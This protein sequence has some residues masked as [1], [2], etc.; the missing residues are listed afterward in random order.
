M[1]KKLLQAD[2][3]PPLVRAL[4]WLVLMLSLA[5]TYWVWHEDQV[6][7]QENLQEEF[8]FRVAETIQRIGTRMSSYELALRGA[9]GLFQASDEV[10]RAEFRSYVDTLRLDNT[11]PGI[12]GIGYALRIDPANRKRHVE[13]IR[14]EGFPHYD[15]TPP[16]ER[17][18]Y[19]AIVFLEPFAGANLRA[20]GYDMHS[21]AVRRAAMDSARDEGNATL[22]GKLRLVQEDGRNEQAGFLMYQPVYRKG[23]P[24][25]TPEQRRAAL[26][27][28][29]Y[30]PFRAGNLMAGITGKYL[31]ESVSALELEIYDAGTISPAALL[32]QS[33]DAQ[34]GAVRQAKFIAS[35]NLMIGRHPWT[36][37]IRS[38][39]TFEAKLHSEKTTRVAVIGVIGSLLLSLIVWQLVHGRER[40][41][42]FARLLNQ[43]LIESEA[44]FRNMADSAPI[45]IWMA[46]TDLSYFWFNQGWLEFTGRTLKEEAG[47]GWLAGIHPDNLETRR[48]TIDEALKHHRPFKSQH[49]LRHHDGEH[50]WVLESAVPRFDDSG[51][52]SGYIGSCTDVT[53]SKVN[54]QVLEQMMSEAYAANRAKSEFLATMSHEIRTPMNGV[55]GMTDLILET[56]L[57]GEQRRY[58]QV[59][60]NSAESL[61][62]IINDILDLSKI[63]SGKLEIEQIAFNIHSLLDELNELYTLRAAEKSIAFNSVATPDVPVWVRG[64]PTRI[65]QILDNFIGN[66]LKFIQRGQI[67]LRVDLLAAE[68][69][70]VTLRFAV[71]DT[72]IGIAPQQQQ[73]LFTPFSQADSSTTRKYGGTGLGLAICK[74]LT[75]LMGGEIG[76]ESKV[77]EGSTFWF[78]AVFALAKSHAAATPVEASAL[79]TASAPPALLSEAT[80]EIRL[81]LVEDN[82]VNRE[83]AT[84]QLCK[85][86]YNN[87]TVALNGVDA[88]AAVARQPFDLILMDC[89]MPLMDGYQATKKLRASGC[90]LPI[91]AMTANAMQGDRER[92]T[93][94][95]MD[96]YLAKPFTPKQLT[97]ML[98]RW[99]NQNTAAESLPDTQTPPGAPLIFDRTGALERLANDKE[100]LR[101]SLAVMLSDSLE[102]VA[103]LATAIQLGHRDEAGYHA[104]NIRDSAANVGAETLGSAAA[105]LEEM[106]RRGELASL[107]EA[108]R[109]VEK[110]LADFALAVAECL[111]K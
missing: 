7:N 17:D 71:H 58:A 46:D 43:Q 27:G 66:S 2:D 20:F 69:E 67:D 13:G 75:E 14:S 82:P 86:G 40:S 44:R 47:T 8:D 21:E 64:D 78:S 81:L 36:I 91:I 104:G 16:G 19:S 54:E 63:E 92:C 108:L 31:H 83:V 57:D 37:L 72:G 22:S 23:T 62:R 24:H 100:L 73:K 84:V 50:R 80:H 68:P 93:A 5:L 55:I 74:R 107:P 3:L 45:M 38:K 85:L 26:L 11:L 53:A 34:S 25:E 105:A 70:H 35:K 30:A 51:R 59:I 109:Q 48:Q 61:L 33:D 102:R 89:Q 99:I 103:A 32:Y 60:R 110:H 49:L 88:L 76:L 41:F 111:E 106:A 42:K 10:T 56:R 98:K 4:P 18:G 1:L 96:D 90:R 39:P 12:Q 101:S 77:G 79:T 9:V 95:G 6:K 52:F 15:I 29:V 97:H 87:I 28:W 94:A 65:R